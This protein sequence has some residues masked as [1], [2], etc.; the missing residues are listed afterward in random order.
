MFKSTFIKLWI[1]ATCMIMHEILVF[2]KLPRTHMI[3]QFCY[4]NGVVAKGYIFQIYVFNWHLCDSYFLV[5]GSKKLLNRK[6]QL[7][8]PMMYTNI[9]QAEEIKSINNGYFMWHNWKQYSLYNRSRHIYRQLYLKTD[10]T[11]KTC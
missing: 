6:R 9:S 3:C 10:I 4:A 2:V 11:I 8:T 5:T 1:T 7:N